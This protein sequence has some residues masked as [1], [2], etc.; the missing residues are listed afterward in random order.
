MSGYQTNDWKWFLRDLETQVDQHM[1]PDSNEV[2]KSAVAKGKTSPQKLDPVVAPNAVVKAIARSYGT[3]TETRE[4]CINA[5][6]EEMPVVPTK[7]GKK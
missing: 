4:G 1:Q 5:D 3:F 2:E 7:G 6:D